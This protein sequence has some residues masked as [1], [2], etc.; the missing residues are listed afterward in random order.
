VRAALAGVV[1]GLALVA[2]ISFDLDRRQFRCDDDPT[3]CGEGYGC[4]AEGFCVEGVSDAGPGIDGDVD[5]CAGRCGEPD[6]A[7]CGI[8]CVCMEGVATEV[9]CNDGIDNDGDGLVDCQD[10]D[11]PSCM[12][13]LSCCADGA[14]R[15]SC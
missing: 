8:G 6:G 13:T 11:C 2:C 5:R 14:C 15:M 12:G 4:G 10:P 9:N 3:V 1:A 7:F